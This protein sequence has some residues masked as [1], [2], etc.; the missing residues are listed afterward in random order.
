[1]FDEYFKPPPSAVSTIISVATLPTPDTTG[2]SSSTTMDQEAPSPSIS[3]NNESTDSLIHSTNVEK[4][5]NEK[6][7]EFDSDTF[8][9]LF[10][11]LVT[12]SDES[13][14]RINLHGLKPFLNGIIKEDLYVSQLEGFVDQVHPNH[15]LRLKKAF[16]GLKQAPRACFSKS[17]RHLHNQSK[18][19]LEMLKKYGLEQCDAV[20][21][22]MVERSKLDEDPNGTPID[23]TRYQGEKLVSWSSKKHKCTAISTTEAEYISFDSQSAIAL[24]CNTVQHSRTKHIAVGYHFI[25]EQVENEVVEL[26]FVKIAY[27]LAD[28]FRKALARDRFEFLI[29]RLGMQ[30]ITPKELKLLAESDE[31]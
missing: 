17:Q 12:S 7:T 28:L 29:K 4:P 8:T 16:Y 13:S 18:Y 22:P 23:P 31:E 5:N 20:D 27:Q 6:V 19:A 11:P 9:N 21:I 3:P 2:A 24:S 15:V 26:Y 30:S 25:I 1:M 14:S 10:A